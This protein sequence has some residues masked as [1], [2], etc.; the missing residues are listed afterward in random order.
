M[1]VSPGRLISRLNPCGS[2]QCFDVLIVSMNHESLIDMYTIPTPSNFFNNTAGIGGGVADVAHSPLRMNGHNKFY[3]N[4]GPALR[5]SV[6]FKFDL[7]LQKI[8]IV[9]KVFMNLFIEFYLIR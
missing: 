2:T 5:V 6:H 8:H 1:P 3:G 4:T 9:V 7:C